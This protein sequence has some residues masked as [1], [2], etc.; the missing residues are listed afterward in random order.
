MIRADGLAYHLLAPEQARH[1]TPTTARVLAANRH[2]PSCRVVVRPSQNF[3]SSSATGGLCAGIIIF[4]HRK[5]M[6]HFLSESKRLY[7]A[8]FGFRLA[9]PCLLPVS[10]PRIAEVKVALTCSTKP[11]AR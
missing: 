11:D 1:A 8:I 2:I 5:H 7:T 6:H 10:H 3:H 9:W 4:I